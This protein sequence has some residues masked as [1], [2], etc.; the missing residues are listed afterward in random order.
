MERDSHGGE[1]KPSS[2]WDL[3]DGTC[4]DKNEI[5]SHLHGDRTLIRLRSD[6]SKRRENYFWF[7]SVLI[8]RSLRWRLK[9]LLRNIHFD[10]LLPTKSWVGEDRGK[11]VN[12]S[13]LIIFV[14]KN[15]QRLIKV[16]KVNSHVLQFFLQQNIIISDWTNFPAI[17]NCFQEKKMALT[18]QLCNSEKPLT[19]IKVTCSIHG[20]IKE[21][22]SILFFFIAKH[23][24][25]SRSQKK[26][27]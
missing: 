20:L 11:H 18:S 17:S 6:F 22:F 19:S 8:D 27:H 5:C 25:S 10:W 23:F 3:I 15:W 9:K 1:T 16:K 13:S 14:K 26:K 12:D 21:I 24:F 4:K 2:N 7:A